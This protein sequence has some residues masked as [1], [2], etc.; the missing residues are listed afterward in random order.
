ML[1]KVPLNYER[2]ESP[3]P[4]PAKGGRLPAR[5]NGGRDVQRA[6]GLPWPGVAGARSTVE[7]GPFP[8]VRTQD[9]EPLGVRNLTA[10]RTGSHRTHA[11]SRDTEP[12]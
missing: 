2:S 8:P 4:E 11:T 7:K 9:R 10:T 5:K 1:Q 12:P 6:Q 3:R